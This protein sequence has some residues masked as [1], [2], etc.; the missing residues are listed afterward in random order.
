MKFQKGQSGNPGGRPKA[1]SE[2]KRLALEKCPEAF[3]KIVEL[4][5]SSDEKIALAAAREV[6]DRGYGKPTQDHQLL[7]DQGKPSAAIL[8]IV[9]AAKEAA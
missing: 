1:D 8:Q 7:D 6:L 5:G 4:M 2:L 9:R 3:T